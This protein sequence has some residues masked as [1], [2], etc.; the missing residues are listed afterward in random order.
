MY[1]NNNHWGFIAHKR[2]GVGGKERS[3]SRALAS[4]VRS[5]NSRSKKLV[6]AQAQSEQNAQ[7]DFGGV[8][9]KSGL[10]QPNTDLKLPPHVTDY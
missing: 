6:E 1:E 10:G 4:L 8:S 2:L 7:S 9:I 3:C 5:P